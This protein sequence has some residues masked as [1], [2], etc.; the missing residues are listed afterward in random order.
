MGKRRKAAPWLKL[1]SKSQGVLPESPPMWL[2]NRSNGEY[3]HE[4]PPNEKLVHRLVLE[5]A[6]A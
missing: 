3:F 4:Q 6:D 2:G 5:R 1:G